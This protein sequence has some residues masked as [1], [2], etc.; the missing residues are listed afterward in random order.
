M[1]ADPAR[2]WIGVRLSLLRA[3]TARHVSRRNCIFVATDCR[4]A[5]RR[6]PDESVDCVVTSPP[7]AHL[8]D[9]GRS[10]QIGYGQA[11]T[12]DYLRDIAGVVQELYRVCSMGS[13][14]WM[15]LDTVKQSGR[16]LSLPWE[17][18][19]RGDKA[20]WVFQDL[21]IWDK[22]RSLPWSHMGRFR[23]VFEYVLLFAKGKL[24][25]F[26]INKVR[27]LDHL[28]SYWVRFP[29]RYNPEGKSPTDIWHFPIPLQG[30]WS[31][32]GIRHF[33]PF[34]IPLVAR[35]IH[36]TTV[37]GDIV[38][39]PF[40]GTGTVA[41]V[42]SFLGRR[43]AGIEVNDRFVERFGRHGYDALKQQTKSEVSRSN[44]RSS[45]AGI[46]PLIIRLRMVKY[47]RTLFAEL[48]RPDRL[49][50]R[51]RQ[52]I[53]ALVLTSRCSSQAARRVTSRGKLGQIE[54][55]VLA[56]RD[57]DLPILC[58]AIHEVVFVPPL[59]KFGLEC[60][61]RV[62][63]PKRWK[64]AS[65]FSR[66]PA[67]KWYL[68][69]KGIFNRYESVLSPEEIVE[70]VQSVVPKGQWKIPPILSTLGVNTNAGIGD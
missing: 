36:L 4:E 3:A 50:E 10:R 29:E 45:R 1:N 21:V 69:S 60:D 51:A 6:L 52:S 57:A 48:A 56:R 32:N 49:G 61:V 67:G 14:L 18:M 26:A 37:P 58:E 7:Y 44:G 53:A 9:Y 62:I 41:A 66:M 30:S 13:A 5:L 68:Y 11:S 2:R 46:G 15:V 35:M 23:G 70:F 33:C 43:G 12:D 19:T 38:L 59:S 39:D 8:K 24:N 65:Y 55:L 28:S 20:G 64:S 25:H 27:A 16:T 31:R 17:V 54:V 42:A 34:P 63:E 40:A 47:P 22:G